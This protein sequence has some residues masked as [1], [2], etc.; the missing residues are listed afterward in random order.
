[1]NYVYENILYQL[2]NHNTILKVII[3]PLKSLLKTVLTLII[4]FGTPTVIWQ[5]SIL[6]R[7]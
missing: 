4:L 5:E 1:M 2:F 7:L 6:L 3:G